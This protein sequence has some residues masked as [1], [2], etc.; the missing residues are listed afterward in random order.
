MPI[1]SIR[2]AKELDLNELNVVMRN[3]KEYWGYDELFLNRYMEHFAITP[4]Y[5]ASAT[6]KVLIIN[7]KICGIYSLSINK[8]DQPELDN[9][10]IHPD[11]IGQGYGKILWQDICKTAKAKGWSILTIWSDPNAQGFYETMG[12][13]KV[14]ER[15]S[16]TSVAS[17]RI[18][19]VMEY[20]LS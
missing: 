8:N 10:F 2:D 3:A 13:Y 9:I 14:G 15:R 19:P 1:F 20:C 12:C 16:P 4:A 6:T 17:N 5:C 7:N 11:Y 18:T